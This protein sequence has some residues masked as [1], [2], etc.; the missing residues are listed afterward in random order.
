MNARDGCSQQPLSRSHSVF[1]N[2]QLALGVVFA[3]V[4]LFFA[5]TAR[6]R[7]LY[8]DDWDWMAPLLSH[9]PL[10][11]YIFVP[12]NEHVIVIP[13]LLMWLDARLNGLPGPLMW[14]VGIGC[15]LLTVAALVQSACRRANLP[16]VAA[17]AFV[18]TTLALLFFTYQLQVFLSPAGI[19][20]PLVVALA[21]VAML[22]VIRAC[23]QTHRGVQGGLWLLGAAL[24]AAGSIVTSGQG[25]AVPFALV[26]MA[27][28]SHTPRSVPISAA[29]LAGAVAAAWLYARSTAL[30][31]LQPPSID[32]HEFG[33]MTLFGLAFL[34]GPVSYASV[35]AG[36]VLGAVIAATGL[37]EGYRV[38]RLGRTPSDCQL[39][40]LGIMVFVFVTTAMT[41]IART[42][43]GVAQAAQSRYALFA[44]LNVSAV[45]ALWTIRVSASDA[46]GRRIRAAYTF[47]FA[48]M[49]AGLP[50]DLFVGAVW[51]AKTENA[52]TAAL[53][54][55]VGARD[56]EWIKT[57]H[58]APSTPYDSSRLASPP[59]FP[60]LPIIDHPAAGTASSTP[61]CDG[62]FYLQRVEPG[63]SFRISGRLSMPAVTAIAVEDGVGV[64]RGLAERA[65]VVREAD[66]SYG[67]V[68]GD[69]WRHIR[70]RSGGDEWFGFA[71]AGSG[72]PYRAFALVNGNATCEA[73]FN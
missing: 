67:Q 71:Q 39:L 61:T 1:S 5:V 64:V 48:L 32:A 35:S 42:R 54:L 73:K 72:P 49:L 9:A 68:V 7:V 51:A 16:A 38:L 6:F 34:A 3:L 17:R 26:A 22:G 31:A 10:S 58:P 14:T 23:R 46:S 33:R 55:R 24:A 11:D 25:L 63:G 69:V 4:F 44:M 57:L 15:Y 52:R 28:A 65:P 66:P 27:L 21:T 41:S 36:A 37:R 30:T 18:A 62:S 40:C 53:A 59:L 20:I 70:H 12:A 19:T 45:L 60:P 43:F 29:L 56:W 2:L 8:K 13:R 50:L 47:V